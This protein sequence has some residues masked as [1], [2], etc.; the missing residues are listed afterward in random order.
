M[1]V[2]ERHGVKLRLFHGRGGT[3]GRGG[4]P[5]YQAILAQP[6]GSVQGQI[7]ITEQGEVIASKYSDPDIGRRNLET[8]VAATLEAT[9]LNR[10]SVRPE[11]SIYREVM[12]EM[13]ADA[14]AAYRKLVYETPGFVT[15]FRTATPITEIADLHVGSR[16]AS[17]KQ[18][19]PHR[20]PARH[21]LGV[22]L[23][24]G[25]HHAARLVRVR[26]RGGAA[27]RAPRRGRAGPAQADVRGMAVLPRRCCPTWTWCWR[28]AT[29]TSPR[30][31]PSWWPMPSCATAS[32]A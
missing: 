11:E 26:H 16:P 4:G 18:V 6:P 15:F 25:A 21:S 22:Q 20:G 29:S 24:A 12:D 30:A 2:F 8:L 32:S 17:R 7:R 13:S 23:V 28:R 10:G 27:R 19:G 3:V 14:F 9:L 1:E 31:T 5:S